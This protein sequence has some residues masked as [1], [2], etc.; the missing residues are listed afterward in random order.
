MGKYLTS[1]PPAK[2]QRGVVLFI[3]LIA[4]VA[5]T[6]AG[7]ALM[8][9]V[10]TANVIAG[11]F[12]FKESTVHATDIGTENAVA[13]LATIVGGA[14]NVAK[15]STTASP[16]QYFPV[17][18]NLNAAG[19]PIPEPVSAQGLSPNV[20]WSAV[21]KAPINDQS[22]NYTGNDVQTVIERMCDPIPSSP[23]GPVQT[24]RS[25]VT[26]YCVTVPQCSPGVSINTP[27]FC[28]AGD[29][30]YR[31]TT[32]VTGPRGTISVVQSVVTM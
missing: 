26:D 12:A 27:P 28:V 20:D 31:I 24:N 7:L 10:D 11:N 2:R 25:D 5:M 30:N 3:A 16:I 29:I 23:N 1:M 18:R 21:K 22:G 6:L 14:G 19:Q 9:S 17:W 4:L 8:R 13:G 15:A 32:R